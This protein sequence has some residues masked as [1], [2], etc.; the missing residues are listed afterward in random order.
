MA[1]VADRVLT[2]RDGELASDETVE[3]EPIELV[4]ANQQATTHESPIPAEPSVM[5]RKAGARV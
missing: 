2:I 3:A 4:F 5:A 1:R